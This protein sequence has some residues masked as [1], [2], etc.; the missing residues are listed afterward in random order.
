[1]VRLSAEE[2][3]TTRSFNIE[4]ESDRPLL[5]LEYVSPKTKEKD[6]KDSYRKY[7]RN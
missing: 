4:L 6:Y 7:E 5:V 3:K 2:P 1:M